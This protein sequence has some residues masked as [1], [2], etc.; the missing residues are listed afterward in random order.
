MDDIREAR[1][2]DANAI[3]ALA[4]ETYAGAFGH[5][6]TEADLRAHL[7]NHLSPAQ[8]AKMLR[9]DTFLLASVAGDIVGFVQFGQASI[10][11]Q[12]LVA[13]PGDKEIQRLYV[14]A[15][16][17]NR[18]LGSRLMEA[19]L[20]HPT[21]ATGDSVLLDVWQDNRRAQQFY[22]R[23]GFEKVAEKRFEVESG[24]ATGVDFVMIRRS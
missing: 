9:T 4:K 2:D 6:M 19:A 5:S 13:V 23:Y 11:M 17:Q 15:T 8:I 12:H 1:P 3:S 21:L 20:A 18:G 10:E 22:A 14:L 24:V 16:H 7:E